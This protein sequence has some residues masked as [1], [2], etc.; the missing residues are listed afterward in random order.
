MKVMVIYLYIELMLEVFYPILTSYNH[1][2]GL[3]HIYA[4]F[5]SY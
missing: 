3:Y 1:I 4:K 2:V 5:I